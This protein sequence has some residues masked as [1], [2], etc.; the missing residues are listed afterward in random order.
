VCLTHFCLSILQNVK[1]ILKN[2]HRVPKSPQVSTAG[3][4]G[5]DREVVRRDRLVRRFFWL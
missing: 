3:D 1:S 2:A 4:V 5:E